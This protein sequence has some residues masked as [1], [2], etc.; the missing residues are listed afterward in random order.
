MLIRIRGKIKLISCLLTSS[1]EMLCASN[2]TEQPAKNNRA[3]DQKH[4]L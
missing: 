1:V 3:L 2:N 4:A